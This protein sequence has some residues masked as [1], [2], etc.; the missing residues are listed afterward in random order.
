[1]NKEVLQLK[2]WGTI[3]FWIL[4]S[5]IW[6]SI[7]LIVKLL[8]KQNNLQILLIGH[9]ENTSQSQNR[10]KWT[11]SL[12]VR[13][14]NSSKFSSILLQRQMFLRIPRSHFFPGV[15]GSY[16]TG[17]NALQKWSH[18]APFFLYFNFEVKIAPKY[19]WKKKVLELILEI[20]CDIFKLK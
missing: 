19:S 18:S 12:K 8:K 14:K 17:E 4:T 3:F 13:M 7:I 20:N 11:Q 16:N 15:N 1:M 10:L 2:Y 9:E 5:R 6:Y